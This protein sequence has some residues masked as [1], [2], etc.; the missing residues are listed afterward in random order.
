[1]LFVTIILFSLFNLIKIYKFL[2]NMRITESYELEK[3]L[4]IAKSDT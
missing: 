4:K 2:Y 1:M 3:T